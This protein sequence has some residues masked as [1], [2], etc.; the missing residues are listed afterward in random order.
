[1]ATRFA[2]IP[3]VK[4]ARHDCNRSSR[5]VKCFIKKMFAKVIGY[6]K[7]GISDRRARGTRRFV[8]ALFIL[9]FPVEH[10]VF[11]LAEKFLDVLKIPIN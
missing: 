9:D 6:T 3:S 8:C 4:F 11:E 5:K 10:Y 7:R 2:G 1:M